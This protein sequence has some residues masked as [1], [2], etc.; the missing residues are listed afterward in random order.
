MG[1]LSLCWKYFLKVYLSLLPIITGVGVATMTEAS[2]DSVGLAS[3]LTST[4]CF[5]LLT[6]FTKKVTGFHLLLLNGYQ[7][8][9]GSEGKIGKWI[10]E[11]F[12]D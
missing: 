7:L 2:F 1:H 11:W 6:I 10:A 9:L 12:E 3:A 4:V 5:S 8:F